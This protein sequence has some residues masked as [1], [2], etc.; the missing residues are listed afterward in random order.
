M[1]GPKRSISDAI[2][3]RSG[4]ATTSSPFRLGLHAAAQDSRINVKAGCCLRK[5]VP[6]APTRPEIPKFAGESLG[7]QM[8]LPTFRNVAP[9][10]KTAGA[11]NYFEFM[12][13]PRGGTKMNDF[14]G[15]KNSLGSNCLIAFQS[16]SEQLP[17]PALKAMPSLAANTATHR[18]RQSSILAA[19]HGIQATSLR[20]QITSSAKLHSSNFLLSSG[21]SLFRSI[22]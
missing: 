4:S 22:D 10:F 6:A 19:P 15:L 8:R 17:K 13:L 9:N 14:N 12:A 18:R 2:S 11:T 1:I 7:H 3:R 21:S 16:V 20:L 5:R